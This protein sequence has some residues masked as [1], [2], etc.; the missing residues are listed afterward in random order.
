[1]VT[2]AD[3]DLE[4]VKTEVSGAD[5]VVMNVTAVTGKQPINK[6]TPIEIGVANSGVTVIAEYEAEVYEAAA[7]VIDWPRELRRR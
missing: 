4:T 3:P 5:K 7:E 1:M 2:F 6:K